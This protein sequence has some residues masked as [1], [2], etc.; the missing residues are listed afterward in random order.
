LP[1]KN[2]FTD[3]KGNALSDALE[4]FIY[5]QRVIKDPGA[6]QQAGAVTIICA[7]KVLYEEK[8]EK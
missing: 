5:R 2:L 1:L 6:N 4:S 3:Q 8:M 7:A